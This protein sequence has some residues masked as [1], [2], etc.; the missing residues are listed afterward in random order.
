MSENFEVGDRVR[1]KRGGHKGI[2][3]SSVEFISEVTGEDERMIIV[4]L[5]NGHSSMTFASRIE[6]YKEEYSLWEVL[7]WLEINKYPDW[8]IIYD[9]DGNPKLTVINSKTYGVHI[10]G[11]NG[12]TADLSSEYLNAKYLLE[13]PSSSK[14]IKPLDRRD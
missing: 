8:T 7:D 2:V 5:D 3:K 14:K 12:K 1:F 13:E 9:S 4:D 10:V 6:M 11:T